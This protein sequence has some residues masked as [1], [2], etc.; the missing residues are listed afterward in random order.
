ML[1]SIKI[2]CLWT[3]KCFVFCDQAIYLTWI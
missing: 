3:R 2:S 1:S